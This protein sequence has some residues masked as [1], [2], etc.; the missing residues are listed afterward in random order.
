MSEFSL[1]SKGSFDKTEAWLRGL[2]R[3]D[4]LN[5]LERFGREGVNA[6]RAATPVESGETANSWTYEVK[7]DAT[8]YS[9][10]WSNTHIEK[11]API[12]ILLQ[13]G[14]GTGTGGYVQGRDYIN[15]VMR[16]IFDRMADAGWK[17]VISG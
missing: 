15:P 14:H 10:I 3:L 4:A 9:I 7:K 11:G 12:A 5:V 6:L 17:V 2:A 8:S 1:E 16:P 13:H